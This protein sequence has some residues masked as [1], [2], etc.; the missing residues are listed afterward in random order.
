MKKIAI[1]FVS[2]CMLLTAGSAAYA[3]APVVDKKHEQKMHAG[4]KKVIEKKIH[5]K[6]THKKVHKMHAKKTGPVHKLH[7][8]SLKTKS[9]KAKAITELPKTGY[10]GASEQTE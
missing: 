3:A 6:A 4:K 8:K 10:G 5:A 2:A 9:L 1:T 7:A